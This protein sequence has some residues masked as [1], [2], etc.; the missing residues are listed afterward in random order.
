M[1]LDLAGRRRVLFFGGKGGVGKTSVAAAVGLAQARAGRKVLLVSTD[2]AHNL[3]HLW[4]R[5][6]GPEVVGLADQ[7]DGV[8]IDPEATTDE[9]LSAVRETLY[10][11]MPQHL[12]GEVDRYLNLSRQ[13]PGTHEAA[14]LE[15]IAGVLQTGLPSYDLIVFDT[16][17]SGHTSRLMAL[18]EIMASWTEG[19]LRNRRRS[20]K[21]GAA[22]RGLTRDTNRSGLVEDTPHDPLV[23]RDL[24]IRRILLARRERFEALRDTLRDEA[25]TSFVVV[26]TAERLPV[27]ES[28]ELHGHLRAAGVHVGQLVVNRRSPADA[29]EFLMQR[30]ELEEQFMEMLSGKLPGIPVTELPLLPGELVGADAVGRFADM[31]G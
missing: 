28:V 15:R 17:P 8:E 30:R 29:G 31:M 18:P 4:Q 9:H 26:L 1:L 25:L 11:V 20:E 24:R 16:A 6:I 2:P 27:L 3:G 22:V 21:L 10:S 5:T 12:R 13:S 14:V 23:E 19:L 7:L